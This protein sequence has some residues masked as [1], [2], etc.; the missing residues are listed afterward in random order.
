MQIGHSSDGCGLDQAHTTIGGIWK[1]CYRFLIYDTYNC[2]IVVVM[3][4]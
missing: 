4:V 1:T 2:F 3:M